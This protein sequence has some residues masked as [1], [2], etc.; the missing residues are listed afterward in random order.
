MCAM[1][2]VSN[3]TEALDDALDR[4]ARLDFE[5]ANGFVN[6]GPMACE[7]LATLGCNDHIAGWAN[8]FVEHVDRG[9]DPV[10]PSR[11]GE[12][13]WTDALGDYARLPEW[14]GYFQHALAT[15]GW[16][17]VV[18]RWVP[19]LMPA[20]S[21]ALFHGAIRTAHAVRAITVVENRPRREELARSLGYWAARY[22]PGA[23]PAAPVVVE[24]TRAAVAGEAA[25]AARHY[26]ARPGI[27]HLHGVTG[28]MAVELLVDHLAP[29]DGNAALAQ[30]RADHGAL[31]RGEPE[32][33]TTAATTWDPE[34]VR[35]AAASR[36]A[37]QVKLVEACR[38]ALAVADDPA[39]AAAAIR[40]T[41]PG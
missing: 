22:R 13:R 9:P 11:G 18:E 29:A 21:T 35:L 25:R 3:T 4:M 1:T 32:A 17:A 31:F 30:V 40:T 14:I 24:D 34:V 28:A 7:A 39:F 37:H 2:T 36:D 15:D 33:A 23:S 19:L 38:R 5:L 16:P 20:L 26:L 41:H 8:W 27:V 12:D 10:H 6:H